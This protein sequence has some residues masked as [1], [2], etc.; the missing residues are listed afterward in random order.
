M[1][2]P[3]ARPRRCRGCFIVDMITVI[4]AIIS[5]IDIVAVI[6]ATLPKGDTRPR[7]S[8]AWAPAAGLAPPRLG[9]KDRP[10]L[11]RR[12]RS[13]WRAGRSAVAIAAAAAVIPVIVAIEV[14]GCGCHCCWCWCLRRCWV[15]LGGSGC[16][17]RVGGGCCCWL[18]LPPLPL[19]SRCSQPLQ[20]A[21]VVA[22]VAAATLAS[23]G[24]CASGG[25]TAGTS[26]SEGPQIQLRQ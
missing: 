3:A 23:G 25:L 20:S 15:A 2:D 22:L 4:I 19:L 24:W 11:A 10:W 1:L 6:I 13:L 17:G 8:T 5:D 16:G 21:P 7:Y 18:S 9:S 26:P 14:T 12:S